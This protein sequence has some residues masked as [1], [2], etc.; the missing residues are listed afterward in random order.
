MLEWL[1]AGMACLSCL[2]AAAF[3]EF[4][5]WLAIP[6]SMF[7]LVVCRIQQ[8]QML[9]ISHGRILLANPARS[10]VLK[11][12]ADS[13]G[14]CVYPIHFW[15]HFFGL[16]MTLKIGNGP[17]KE[18]KSV[19]IMVWRCELPPEVYRRLCVMVNWQVQQLQKEQCLESE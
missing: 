13:T 14:L 6:V 15:H 19:R 3:L 1:A 17:Q 4:S 8:R 2:V 5:L 9:A 7:P 10:W 18:S 12:M 16:S 11:K